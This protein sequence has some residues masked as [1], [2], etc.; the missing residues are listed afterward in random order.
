R[1]LGELPV[2]LTRDDRFIVNS[3]GFVR[4]IG[5]LLT[6]TARGE[7]EASLAGIETFEPEAINATGIQLDYDPELLAVMVLRIDPRR[8]VPESLIRGGTP[9]PPDQGPETFSAYLNT[10]LSVQRRSSTGDIDR[11]SVFLNGAVNFGGV[12]FEADVQGRDDRFTD[13]YEV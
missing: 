3:E 6:E 4:L 8:R 7:L 12:V 13:S 5:P 1:V 9:D 11:P 2:V 10:N